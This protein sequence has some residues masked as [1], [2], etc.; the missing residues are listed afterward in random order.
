M[1]YAVTVTFA[2]ALGWLSFL[3]HEDV[4]GAII[5]TLVVMYVLL[6]ISNRP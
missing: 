1:K 6:I 4:L 5:V 3:V 2:A